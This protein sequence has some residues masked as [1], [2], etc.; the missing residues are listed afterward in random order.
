MKKRLVIAGI[1]LGLVVVVAI[2]ALRQRRVPSEKAIRV[3]GTVEVTT[4]EA[5]FKIPGRIKARLVDEGD[6]VK[7]GQV[8]ARLDDDDQLRDVARLRAES[9]A[10]KA[11]LAEL[12]AGSRREEIAQAEAALAAAEAEAKRLDDDLRRQEALYR[13]EVIARRE[14][15]ATRA[16]RDTS[17]AKAQEAREALALV[18]KGPRQER[19]DQARARYRSTEDALALAQNRLDYTTLCAPLAGLVLAKNAEPGEQVAAGTPVVTVGNI[20]DT[21]VRSY[22]NETDLGRVKTGQ[23][24]RVTSDTWPGKVYDGTVTFIAQ[25]AEFTPK[26]VQTEKERVKLV[27][28][29]KI[30]VP[31]PAM[32]LKPGM[33]VDAEIVTAAGDRAPGT[34]K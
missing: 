5:S 1:A 29:I 14:L 32:E 2:L 22:I 21:W 9:Q 19:I 23:K 17:R 33:P 15:D 16:G 30:T 34:G 4:V 25:E 31:N 13:R 24:A 7:A 11:A 28:R 27:Y 12:E 8:I 26:N 3:S 18:R 6:M 20:A 10:A